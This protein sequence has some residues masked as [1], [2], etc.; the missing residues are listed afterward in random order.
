MLYILTKAFSYTF[1]FL[2]SRTVRPLERLSPLHKLVLLATLSMF[3]MAFIVLWLANGARSELD[4][5]CKSLLHIAADSPRS[6]RSLCLFRSA[7]LQ[8]SSKRQ[9]G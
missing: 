2:K 9:C 1:F 8:V 7:G 5:T 4:G 6:I 3:G